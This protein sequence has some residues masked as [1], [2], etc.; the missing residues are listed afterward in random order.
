MPGS[1]TDDSVHAEIGWI[2]CIRISQQ[3][4]RLKS[5]VG[6]VRQR[7]HRCEQQMPEEEL[8]ELR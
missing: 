1:M 8:N 4:I 2:H 3:D 6:L 7:R 5:F